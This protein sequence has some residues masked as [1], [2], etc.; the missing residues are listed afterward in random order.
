[1]SSE[2]EAAL[3]EWREALREW[4]AGSRTTD[5]ARKL[6]RSWLDYKVAVGAIHEDQMVLVADDQGGYVA[7]TGTLE[8]NLGIDRKSLLG[9]TVADVTPPR[10]R[11]EAAAAW[12]EFVRLGSARGRY[13]LR[14]LD[15]QEVEMT[16]EATAN[17]PAAGLHVSYLV[18][19]EGSEASRAPTGQAAEAV[20][21]SGSLLTSPTAGTDAPGSEDQGMR[22][23]V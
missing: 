11:A 19:A 2:V 18:P 20:G 15:G 9:M 4:E 16:F 23:A 12:A 21:R 17:I 5:A 8:R 22:E 7:A 13:R 6:A 10:E 1:M 3:A 14:H